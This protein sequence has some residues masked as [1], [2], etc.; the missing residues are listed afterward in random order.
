MMREQKLL[1]VK[2]MH[3]PLLLMKQIAAGKLSKYNN[4]V[5]LNDMADFEE[6]ELGLRE[7]LVFEFMDKGAQ[8]MFGKHVVKQK[9]EGSERCLTC[10][11]KELGVVLCDCKTVSFCS[12]KCKTQNAKHA[13]ICRKIVQEKNPLGSLLQTYNVNKDVRIPS[14]FRSYGKTGLENIGNTCFLNSAVQCIAN[15][16]DLTMFFLKNE[17]LSDINL[18]NPLGSEGKLACAYGEFLKELFF[19]TRRTA[20]P[21]ALKKIIER[22]NN[23]FTGFSQQDSQEFLSYFLDLLHEDLNRVKTKPSVENI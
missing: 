18:R 11:K 20:D 17:H 8:S 7:F 13:E 14:D 12:Q 4:I 2:G 21:R 10:L 1:V 5:E 3:D 22:K 15:I 16:E 23:Q 9:I 6:F 19:T